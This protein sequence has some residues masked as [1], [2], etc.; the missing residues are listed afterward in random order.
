M[1]SQVMRLSQGFY[2]SRFLFQVEML[3]IVCGCLAWIFS[4][5]EAGISSST[6]L[7]GFSNLVLGDHFISLVYQVR[8][9]NVLE[10]QF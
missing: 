4:D 1:A 2:F 6:E 10:A 7:C 8:N 9:A 5:G 3:W